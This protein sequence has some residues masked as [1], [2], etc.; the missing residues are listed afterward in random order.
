[1][2]LKQKSHSRK[3]GIPYES[4]KL[5]ALQSVIHKDKLQRPLELRLGD[6]P[7]TGLSLGQPNLEC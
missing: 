6:T 7:A 4:G 3:R 5:P 1:M 2:L